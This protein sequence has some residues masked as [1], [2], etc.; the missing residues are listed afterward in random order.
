L[1]KYH[2]ASANSYAESFA[3]SEPDPDDFSGTI[4]AFR[5]LVAAR[6]FAVPDLRISDFEP[7]W[8]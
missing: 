1:G 7:S 8:N 4:S 2:P 6:R 3:I 5:Y